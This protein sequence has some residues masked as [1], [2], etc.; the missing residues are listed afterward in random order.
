MELSAARFGI[1]P[2]AMSGHVGRLSS[3]AQ[4]RAIAVYLV[5]KHTLATADQI[6]TAFGLED[7][8]KQ[9]IYQIANHGEDLALTDEHL[10]G[11][12]ELIE[13]DIDRLHAERPPPPAI[14]RKP[15]PCPTC[16]AKR[17]QEQSGASA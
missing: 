8:S 12:C 6:K 17:R 10:S 2:E 7:I 4:P 16:G 1:T 14:P 9:A 15:A 5:R 11:V 3:A 13:R